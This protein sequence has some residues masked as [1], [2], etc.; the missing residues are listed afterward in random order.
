ML[1]VLL[2]PSFSLFSLEMITYWL[3]DGSGG[4]LIVRQRI[5]TDLYIKEGNITQTIILHFKR[6]FIKT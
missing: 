2:G 5:T 4:D 6:L 3:N 1:N